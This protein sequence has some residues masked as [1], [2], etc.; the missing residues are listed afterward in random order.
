MG[1][2]VKLKAPIKPPSVDVASRVK[3]P[4]KFRGFG[5]GILKDPSQANPR[6]FTENPMMAHGGEY[7]FNEIVDPITGQRRQ[8]TPEDRQREMERYTI[9]KDMMQSQDRNSL[10]AQQAQGQAVMGVAGG[11]QPDQ[12]IQQQNKFNM[13]RN[14]LQKQ[15]Q[16]PMGQP[17]MGQP[18]QAMAQAP[19]GQ[20]PQSPIKPIQPVPP[21]PEAPKAQAPAPQ[22]AGAAPQQETDEEKKR[23]LAGQAL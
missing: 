22:I 2:S 12:V 13:L 7:N 20:P 6:G 19:M 17:P 11:P 8:R 15:P 16:A 14:T 23:K 3:P 4:K 21:L 9:K 5:S 1:G 10:L 18:Q